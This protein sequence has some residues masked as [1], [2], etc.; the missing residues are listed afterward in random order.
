MI[1]LLK[2]LVAVFN[3]YQ[4]VW[5][6]LH[7]SSWLFCCYCLYI[8]LVYTSQPKFPSLSFTQFLWQTFPLPPA[9]SLLHCFSSDSG[10]P[11]MDIRQSAK[12]YQVAVRL[13]S[14]IKSG[15]G[16]PV[17]GM[18]PKC[19]HQNQGLSIRSL[20]RGPLDKTVTYMQSF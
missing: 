20:T 12:M 10:R 6:T 1:K 13:A 7:K 4:D 9:N 11:P 2:V 16:K 19:R 8:T 5:Y 15:W 18:G 17:G 3:V 14:F